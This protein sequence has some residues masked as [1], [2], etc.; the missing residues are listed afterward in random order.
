MNHQ[1]KKS[2]AHKKKTKAEINTTKSI[3]KRR[4]SRTQK[5]GHVS[6]ND[7]NESLQSLQGRTLKNK[8]CEG[9]LC[10][11]LPFFILID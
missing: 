6:Y 2:Y 4:K 1:G 7:N 5:S 9:E 11:S 8:N 10:C 3:A